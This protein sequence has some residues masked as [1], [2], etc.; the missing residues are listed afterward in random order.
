M[1]AGIWVKTNQKLPCLV[2]PSPFYFVQVTYS[3]CASVSSSVKMVPTSYIAV[4]M[5]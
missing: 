3:L 2:C 4:S 1:G 5:K